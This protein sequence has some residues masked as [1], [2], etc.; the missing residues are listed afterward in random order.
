MTYNYL[1]GSTMPTVDVTHSIPV[2]QPRP[3]LYSSE[4]HG[5]WVVRCFCR[6]DCTTQFDR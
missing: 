5:W 2:D 6:G 3:E 1:S 4:L